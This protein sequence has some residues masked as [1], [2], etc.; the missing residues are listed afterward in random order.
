MPILK[1]EPFAG[2]ETMDELLGI[3]YAMEQEAIAGYSA[4]AAR[5]RQENEPEL[6]A[7]FDRLVEEES[8][9]LGNVV[10]WSEKIS[11][12]APDLGNVRWELAPTFDDEG[13][14]TVAPE[15]LSAYRAFSMAVRNEERAFVFWTYVAAQTD[16]QPLR[17][18]AERMA[19][20]E[21]G[22]L[23]T[24]RRERRRA[25]HT[26]RPS[27][28]P[29]AEERD[30][31]VLERRLAEHLE[32]AASAATDDAAP[33]AEQA[34]RARERSDS[35]ARKPLGDSPLLRGGVAADVAARMVPLCELLLDCYLDFAERL[36]EESERNR[37]QAF[38]AGTIQ[39]RSALRHLA[40]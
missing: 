30:L 33:L 32:A 7:V 16:R 19:H 3:A 11:G 5:M 35:L 36:P 2:V 13:A 40:R 38:A 27:I 37:A 34:R 21:L 9:H 17:E 23:A 29:T 14:G 26:E 31:A 15:L 25:F 1:A 28:L 10:G 4:L 24:L 12:K 18:A 39:C 20:E 22:H 6:A 8:R